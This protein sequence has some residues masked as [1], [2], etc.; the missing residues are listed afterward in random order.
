MKRRFPRDLES[1][2]QAAVD[3]EQARLAQM[4]EAEKRLRDEV[5]SLRSRREELHLHGATGDLA[6]QVRLSE[7]TA[8]CDGRLASLMRELA[9]HR[10]EREV[11]TAAVRRAFGRRQAVSAL[12]ETQCLNARA[13]R[14]RADHR[15]FGGNHTS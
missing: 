3:G 2:L 5:A 8:W 9:A 7:W 12:I 14:R 1:L 11:L 10:A 15:N 4:L 6:Y 13:E